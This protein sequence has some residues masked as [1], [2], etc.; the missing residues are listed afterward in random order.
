MASGSA[1][2]PLRPLF[3]DR[4]NPSHSR[5][6][7]LLRP[8]PLLPVHLGFACLTL[9][10][11]ADGVRVKSHAAADDPA[12][13]RRPLDFAPSQEDQPDEPFSSAD[14]RTPGRS[15]RRKDE[16]WLDWE[17]VILEDTVPLVSFVRMILHS[18]KYKSGDRLIP[19]HEKTILERLL[20]YHPQSQKKIGCGIDYITI[21]YHPQ[22]E[23]SRCLFIARMNGDLEDFS[24]WKCIK[25]FIRKN[26]P[27]Y[28][29]SFILRHF[30][31]RRY[32]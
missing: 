9:R 7:S 4:C 12:L 15:R 10:S 2:F 30:R 14:R 21:G 31:R 5:L 16:D 11:T 22:F 25:G 20:P 24:Y 19:E 13:L 17:D 1:Y 6:S 32:D 29:D 3:H 27:L 28:A 26:Y 8:S 23:N 18:G